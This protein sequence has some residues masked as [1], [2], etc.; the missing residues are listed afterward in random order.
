M[1][2][3]RIAGIIFLVIAAIFL[4]VFSSTGN[5]VFLAAA[6]F[7]AVVGILL[8]IFGSKLAGVFGL[9]NVPK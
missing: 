7:C 9:A 1:D 3:Y 8:L 2:K 6:I 4:F 5:T